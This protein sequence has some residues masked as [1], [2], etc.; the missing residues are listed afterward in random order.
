MISLPSTQTLKAQ[1][2]CAIN[3]SCDAAPALTQGTETDVEWEISFSPLEPYFWL[4][5]TDAKATLQGNQLPI[6]LDF[7]EDAV[8]NMGEGI[9]VRIE[10]HLFAEKNKWSIIIDP[11]RLTA[12]SSGEIG[13]L[14]LST[15]STFKMSDVKIGYEISQG[16]DLFAGARY[17]SQELKLNSPSFDNRLKGSND[18]W[19]PVLGI[20]YQYDISQHWRFSTGAYIGGIQRSDDDDYTSSANILFTYKY[21]K[22]LDFNIGYRALNVNMSQGNGARLFKF[23]ATYKGPLIGLNIDFF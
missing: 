10:L 13:E 22:W 4:A 2:Q 11:T 14:N 8:D 19:S 16:L 7:F 1:E 21:L 12:D 3:S 15:R 20:R 5:N 6:D 23:D 9:H 17:T 18:W